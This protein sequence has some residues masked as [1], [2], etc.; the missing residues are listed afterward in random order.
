MHLPFLVPQRSCS[1]EDLYS[2]YAST[3]QEVIPKGTDLH[4]F[5]D[6]HGYK[7]SFPAKSRNKET[8]RIKECAR[9]I[10]TWMDENRHKMN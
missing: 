4:G 6:D 7:N 9:D 10:T 3:L 5:A 2:A 1:G 8:T